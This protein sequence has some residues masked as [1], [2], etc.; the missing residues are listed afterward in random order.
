MSSSRRLG[1]DLILVGIILFGVGIGYLSFGQI[2][3][4]VFFL[5]LIGFVFIVIGYLILRPP[6]EKKTS[7]ALSKQKLICPICK[8]IVDKENAVCPKCGRLL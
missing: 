8:I 4:F 2:H 7:P 6:K 3:G 1:I 5:V